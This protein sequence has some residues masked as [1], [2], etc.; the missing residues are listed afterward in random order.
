MWQWVSYLSNSSRDYH[1]VL[2]SEGISIVEEKPSRMNSIKL[3]K[4]VVSMY[5]ILGSM[6]VLRNWASKVESDEWEAK[7]TIKKLYVYNACNIY[8]GEILLK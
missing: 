7:V 6:S 8:H 4:N 3:Q 5:Y 1:N 2:A